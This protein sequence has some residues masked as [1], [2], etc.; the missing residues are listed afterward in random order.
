MV[1]T[2]KEEPTKNDPHR[3][4]NFVKEALSSK[5]KNKYQREITS[6]SLQDLLTDIKVVNTK[7]IMQDNEKARRQ[8]NFQYGYYMKK[9]T[10]NEFPKELYRTLEPKNDDN[11]E[12]I[13][14]H[15]G[16]IDIADNGQF[17]FYSFSIPKV[18]AKIP[19]K[20]RNKYFKSYDKV[21]ESL[22]ETAGVDRYGNPKPTHEN[23]H[24]ASLVG[25]RQKKALDLHMR[26][27]Y[28]NDQNTEIDSNQFYTFQNEYKPIFVGG[29]RKTRK[30]K[31]RLRKNTRKPRKSKKSRKSYKK[32][33]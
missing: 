23:A 32:R 12:I 8:A 20:D 31:K 21:I 3:Y 22:N 5:K 1:T 11:G 4:L 6:D 2:Q 9:N 14:S 18:V 33:R 19:L 30:N 27:Q 13:V 29:K 24:F 15:I 28:R 17:K 25:E 26:I 10:D 16:T 7:L